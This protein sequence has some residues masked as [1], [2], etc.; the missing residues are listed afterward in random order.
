[1][2][3]D[4]FTAA[5]VADILGCDLESAEVL[6]SGHVWFSPDEVIQLAEGKGL[7]EL[8]VGYRRNGWN[9]TIEIHK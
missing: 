5:E 6:L 7:E 4:Q 2:I 1:M 8:T 3:P 9:F